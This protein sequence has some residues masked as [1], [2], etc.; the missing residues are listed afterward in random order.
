VAADRLQAVVLDDLPCRFAVGET[1]ELWIACASKI[2]AQLDLIDADALELL[3]QIDEL[4]VRDH[5]AVRIR[6]AAHRQAQ[7]IRGRR[8]RAGQHEPG[9]PGRRLSNEVP[10]RH[11]VHR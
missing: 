8:P 1:L 11:R 9:R 6:L 3:E 4:A 5:R 7:R 10:S 2:A